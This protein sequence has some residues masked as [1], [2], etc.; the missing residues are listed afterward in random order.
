MENLFCQRFNFFIVIFSRDRRSCQRKHP[1]KAYGDS[2][3][4]VCS[5][6]LGCANNIS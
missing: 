1:D 6:H 3:D 5:L 4:W 2:L